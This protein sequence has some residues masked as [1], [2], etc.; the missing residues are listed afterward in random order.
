MSKA[1]LYVCLF[2]YF[3][4]HLKEKKIRELLKLL[5]NYPLEKFKKNKRLS[6]TNKIN[7]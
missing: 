7:I 5:R 3:K 4:L 2:I 1:Y 6:Q